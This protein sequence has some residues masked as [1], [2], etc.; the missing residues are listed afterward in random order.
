MTNLDSILK[1]REYDDLTTTWTLKQNKA[2]KQMGDCRAGD[3][4]TPGRGLR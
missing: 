4:V 3:W 2:H 1:S